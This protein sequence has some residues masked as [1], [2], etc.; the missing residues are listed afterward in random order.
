MRAAGRGRRH[1][2]DVIA[3][4]GSADRL[5][6]DGAIVGKIGHRHP[7]ARRLHR[8]DD[9][10][11]HRPLIEASRAATGDGLE[12]RGEVVEGDV[13][14]GLFHAAVG[15]RNMRADEG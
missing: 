15:L 1:R 5:A 2:D 3:A 4:I 14:A 10:L 6:L 11:R 9:L 13:I 8:G 7:P 12:R